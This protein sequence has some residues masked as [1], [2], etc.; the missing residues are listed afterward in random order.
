MR[1][2][3]A[4]RVWP[5]LPWSPKTTTNPEEQTINVY[6]LSKFLA[7]VAMTS[8]ITAISVTYFEFPP[9]G[10]G[11]MVFISSV[12]VVMTIG[13]ALLSLILVG[14]LLIR[15]KS[16]PPI[17]PVVVSVLSLALAFSYIWTM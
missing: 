4:V 9:I 14:S 6:R 17:K 16:P 11:G 8:V 7:S 15:R 10:Y 3:T 2:F 13:A 1:A 5:Q 12:A